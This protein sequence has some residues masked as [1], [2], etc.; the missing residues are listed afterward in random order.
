VG[1]FSVHGNSQ[2][3]PV[4]PG[5]S[6]QRSSNCLK[7]L[8]SICLLICAEPNVANSFTAFIDYNDTKHDYKAHY[9]LSMTMKTILLCTIGSA[10][11]VN[12][13]IGIGQELKRRG[14]WAVLITSQYFES[15]TRDAGLEF[16][17]LGSAEDYQR[18]IQNPDLWD[19]D[20]G[21]KV[22]AEKVTIKSFPLNCRNFWTM[23]IL[24][25]SLL[26]VRPC[27]VANNSSLTAWRPLEC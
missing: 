6:T 17:G 14:F 13:F 4:L 24:R 26:L 7:V 10:G 3:T 20:K 5:I 11:D 8:R 27:N 23:G 9:N 1:F 18:I 21:F 16:I 12:P 25:L 15:Q 22:F 2:V 19:A